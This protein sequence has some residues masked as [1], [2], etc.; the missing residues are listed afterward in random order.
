MLSGIRRPMGCWDDRLTHQGA[1]ALP[2]EG[3]K[4]FW[5]LYIGDGRVGVRVELH[6]IH[7]L[8]QGVSGDGREES[9]GKND[10][11]EGR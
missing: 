10:D 11:E 5:D 9:F 8:G 2:I 3:H 4:W 6:P 7:I 1:H